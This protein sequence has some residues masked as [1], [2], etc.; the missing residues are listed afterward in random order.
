M[1]PQAEK[2]WLLPMLI[3]VAVIGVCFLTTRTHM[4]AKAQA[5]LE[6]VSSNEIVA[7][8]IQI[9]RDSFG[10]AMIDKVNQTIWLYEFNDR[11]PVH[12]RLRLL[13]ARSW[14]YDRLLEQYNTGEPRPHQVKRLLES[15][16]QGQQKE[17]QDAVNTNVAESQAPDA[18]EKDQ[19]SVQ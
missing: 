7:M 12:S 13:A 18:A 2:V 3:V 6:T 17:I 9:A 10:L 16:E 15:L 8:P 4:V 5:P 11:G 14:R 19:K 1:K